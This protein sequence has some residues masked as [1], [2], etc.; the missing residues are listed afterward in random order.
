[1]MEFNQIW[2]E[3]IWDNCKWRKEFRM[4]V[5]TFH[6]VL[7]L[8]GRNLKKINTFFRRAIKVEKTVSYYHLKTFHKKFI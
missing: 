5:E 3:T 2:F 7:G 4:S 8:P 6:Y 1:M